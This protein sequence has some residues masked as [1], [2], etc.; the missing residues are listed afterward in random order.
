MTN[1][2]GDRNDFAMPAAWPDLH[3]QADIDSTVGAT[4][5]STDPHDTHSALP[6]LISDVADQACRQLDPTTASP[7]Q[8]P[9]THRTRPPLYAT[10]SI[11]KGGRLADRAP[12][13]YLS[14]LAGTPVSITANRR[15]G[16]I[17]VRR[18]GPHAISN[19]GRLCIPLNTRLRLKIHPNDRLLVAALPD[20]DMAVLY[21]MTALNVMVLA[22]QEASSRARP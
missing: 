4:R 13:R 18:H 1:A 21:T 8:L 6:A 2:Q 5:L 12:L 17:T 14:W 7:P 9:L 11:D 3:R 10:T 16:T 22:Y 15:D 20:Q 19:Q